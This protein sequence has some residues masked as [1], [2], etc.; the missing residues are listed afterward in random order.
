MKFPKFLCTTQISL[1]SVNY[2]EQIVWGY[3]IQNNYKIIRL[4]LIFGQSMSFWIE[5]WRSS[6][7]IKITFCRPVTL[8]KINS[9]TYFFKHFEQRFTWILCRTPMMV[10]NWNW[11]KCSL[12]FSLKKK[13]IYKRL[14]FIILPQHRKL[15][16][17]ISYWHEIF[18][19]LKSPTWD[20]F[21]MY[22]LSFFLYRH[23]TSCGSSFMLLIF[24]HP[25][26]ICLLLNRNEEYLQ[27][28]TNRLDQIIEYLELKVHFTFHK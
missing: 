8:L 17:E 26:V 15:W 18:F 7:F 2:H 6:F 28:K 14:T 24:N 20:W 21:H 4:S 3:S 12:V 9:F 5:M 11:L 19:F 13:Y 23:K 1:M 25:K 22:H 10:M 16:L 27:P